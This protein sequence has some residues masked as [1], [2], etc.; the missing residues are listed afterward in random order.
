MG[1][2][3]G[4]MLTRAMLHSA[5]SKFSKFAVDYICEFDTEFENILHR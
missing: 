3:Y 2:P 4:E 1:L 5:E